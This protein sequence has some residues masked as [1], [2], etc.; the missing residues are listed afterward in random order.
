MTTLQDI[1]GH[2]SGAVYWP[3]SGEI[4]ICN[5][6]NIDGLPRIFATG[7]LIG[8]GEDLSGARR[9]AAPA[10]VKR[11][12]QA[13]EREQGTPVSKTGFRALAVAGAV[14]VTQEGWA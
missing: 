2:E 12:M 6:S 1:T 5:W 9:V 4:I 7:A 13:H 10:A 14:V 8:L 3:E 11:A